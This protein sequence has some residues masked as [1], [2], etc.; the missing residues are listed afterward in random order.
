M[1]K[2]AHPVVAFLKA[3]KGVGPKMQL[4]LSL[5]PATVAQVRPGKAGQAMLADQ[6]MSLVELDAYL[7]E[8]KREQI[9][10]KDFRVDLEDMVQVMTWKVGAVQDSPYP[11]CAG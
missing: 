3:N 1:R 10:E 11:S 7:W 8:H 9:I 4:M 5:Y 6:G 2:G